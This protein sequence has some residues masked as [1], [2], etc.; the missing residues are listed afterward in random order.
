MRLQQNIIYRR[1]IRLSLHALGGYIPRKVCTHYVRLRS[2]GQGFCLE[3]HVHRDLKPSN[4]LVSRTS[5]NRQDRGAFSIKLWTCLSTAR[6]EQIEHDND[7]HCLVHG[8]RDGNW[9]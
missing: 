5:R 1:T 4:V 7:W 9:F 2:Q 6:A 8:T 3:Q